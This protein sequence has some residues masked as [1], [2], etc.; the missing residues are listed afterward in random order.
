MT[1]PLPIELR[2]P[3]GAVR[4][5]ID[6][7]DGRTTIYA[8]RLLRGF[9]PCAV[10]QGHDGGI[11]FLEP[12][13]DGLELSDVASV[14][15]YAIRLAWGDGH[16]TGIYSFRFLRRLSEVDPENMTTEIIRRA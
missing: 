5:E 12:P 10:C 15:E 8:H 9:C 2:A 7:D 13:K 4:L 6:W 16:N 11:E 3:R 1:Q 14:G